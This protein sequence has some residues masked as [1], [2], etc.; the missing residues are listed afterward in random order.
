MTALNNDLQSTQGLSPKEFLRQR[1]PERFSDSTIAEE[2]KLDRQQLEYHLDTLTSR[3]Q[4]ADFERFAR[5][6]A[7]R[8]ICSNLLP[9]TGPTGGGDSKVDSET[10][11][12]ASNLA[13][14]WYVGSDTNAAH[15]RWA[16]AF[17][18]AKKWKAKAKSDIKKLVSTGRGY[19][20]AFF[21]TNQYVSDR[22]RA[23]FEDQLRKTYKLDVRILDRTWILNCVFTGRHSDLVENELKLRIQTKRVTQIGPLDSERECDLEEINTRIDVATQEGRF[24]STLVDDAMDAAE[25][26]RALERPRH[27]VEGLLERADNLASK[28]GTC[29]QL[30]EVAYQKARTTFWWYEDFQ[31][32]PDLYMKVEE[33]AK[34]S[35]NVFDFERLA[36][37]WHILEGYCISKDDQQ[38]ILWLKERT[39]ALKAELE[40]LCGEKTRPS[41]QLQAQM[42]LL[43]IQLGERL[44]VREPPGPILKKQKK[45]IKKAS[46]LTGF[47]LDLTIQQIV[48]IGKY[49]GA[50]PEYEDLFETAVRVSAEQEQNLTAARLLVRRAQQ[51]LEAEQPH[52]AIRKLGRSF[53]LLYNNTGRHES[54]HALYLC[55]VAY[56]QVG[57]LWAARGALVVAASLATDEFWKYGKITRFQTACYDRLRWI[58]LRLGRLPQTLVWNKTYL[59]SKLILIDCGE[60]L[61]KFTENDHAFDASLAIL[62]L[63]A[64][65]LDLRLLTRIPRSL[66]QNELIYAFWALVYSLGHD[67]VVTSQLGRTIDQCK[68]F[69]VNLS[70]QP[71]ADDLPLALDLCN[72]QSITLRSLIFGCEYRVDVENNSPCVEIAESILAA[73]EALLASIPAFQAISFLPELPITIRKSEFARSPFSIEIRDMAGTPQVE[74]EARPFSPHELTSSEQK[75]LRLAI[76]KVVIELMAHSILLNDTEETLSQL[77]EEGAFGRAIDFTSSFVTVG[78]VL[79]HKFSS[80]LSAWEENPS[81]PVLRTK[82][83]NSELAELGQ[84]TNRSISSTGVIKHSELRNVTLIRP[85][86]WEKAG[87]SGMMFLHCQNGNGIPILAPTFEN[88]EAGRDIFKEL[89]NEV[90]SSDEANKLQV[91]IVRGVDRH[92]PHAYRVFF[93]TN[94]D[95]THSNEEF[96]YLAKNGRGNSFNPDNGFNL[97]RFIDDFGRHQEYILAPGFHKNSTVD[98]SIGLLKKHIR[99][100]EAWE[101]GRHDPDSLVIEPDDS[102]FVPDGVKDPPVNELL[103]H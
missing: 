32:V 78:N 8:Q 55:G 100:R 35:R 23:D 79:G 4:E 76:K 49:F 16:F 98:L 31:A 92:Q 42:I 27:E 43:D 20:K 93:D 14:A 37:L 81:Y 88:A 21:I 5:Q 77:S 50:E 18:A 30:V 47:P 6:L 70:C 51:L 69:F 38:Q 84:P 17:S 63:R 24:T 7:E 15:E 96:R 68:D 82:P 64:D 44:A 1:R 34:G 80:N 48:E 60:N 87:W 26:A 86:H 40:R 29:R 83:W 99:F 75:A 94:L 65:I 12:V 59:I 25:L 28:Y 89:L 72:Q 58:E 36:T 53:P 57:L 85:A 67:E 45:I 95:E 66:E 41:T 73:L 11:P 52:D 19:V 103:T 3:S 10:Y 90:G 97:N 102:P 39:E 101:I 56:E 61:D 71:I 62:L 2:R 9:Q 46:T 13:L 91:V 33:R 54:V 74:I 22:T